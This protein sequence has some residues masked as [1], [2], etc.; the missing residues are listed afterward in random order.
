MYSIRSVKDMELQDAL[1][2]VWRVFREFEAPEYSA[3]GIEEFRRY[4]Q[5]DSI[6]VCQAEGLRLWG[7]FDGERINGVIAVR[8]PAHVSLLFVDRDYHRQGIAR[9]LMDTALSGFQQESVATVHASPYGLEAYRRLGF[10]ESGPET[11]VN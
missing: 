9:R 3:E 10:A 5:P 2:L 1:A 4:I 6:R 8:P 11:T 7:S